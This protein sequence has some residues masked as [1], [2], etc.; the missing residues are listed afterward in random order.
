MAN[1]QRPFGL[2]MCHVKVLMFSIVVVVFFFFV[3]LFNLRGSDIEYNPV[4]F[5][6][7]IVGLNTIR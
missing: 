5:A 1:K 3:G 7:A 6:Y 2:L 4:F